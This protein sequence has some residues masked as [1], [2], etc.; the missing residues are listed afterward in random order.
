MRF[1]FLAL[2]GFAGLVWWMLHGEPEYVDTP[3]AHVRL[4]DMS[5]VAEDYDERVQRTIDHEVSSDGNG[6]LRIDVAQRELVTVSVV[7]A[8]SGSTTCG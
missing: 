5:R 1:V 2:A 7:H 3:M 4:D 8:R 6:S